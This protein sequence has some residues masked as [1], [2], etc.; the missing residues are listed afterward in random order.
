MILKND[1]LYTM[2]ILTK[3]IDTSYREEIINDINE[4]LKLA[5]DEEK[6]IPNLETELKLSNCIN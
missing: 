4:H 1:Y 2:Q 3:K 6:I 5:F